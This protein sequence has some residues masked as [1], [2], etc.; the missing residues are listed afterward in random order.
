MFLIQLVHPPGVEKD[1]CQEDQDR[2]LLG[3]PEAKIG[4]ADGNARQRRAQDD[5]EPERDQRPDNEA[6]QDE[7]HIGGPIRV[8]FIVLRHEFVLS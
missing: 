3:E 1:Q 2:A 4:A 6:D 7:T 5:P 8:A